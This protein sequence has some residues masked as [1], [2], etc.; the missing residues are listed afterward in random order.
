MT[1]SRR[2]LI[3]MTAAAAAAAALLPAGA[4]QASSPN[5]PKVKAI[6]FDGF[7]IFDPRPIAAMT[8]Q[9]FPGHGAALTGLWRTKI[10]EYTWL[11][12]SMQRYR[13][14]I[15]VIEDAL[16][17]AARSMSLELTPQK[18]EMLVE[19]YH[20]MKAWPDVAPALQKL[21]AANLRLAYLN[22]FTPKMLT[23]NTTNA[24]LDGF[25]EHKLSTDAVQV[26]KP[27]PRAY[28]MGLD[29]FGL[30]REEILFVAFGGW[31]AVGAKT[32]GYPTFW[33]NRLRVSGEELGAV[34]DGEG[35][36]MDDL[37]KFLAI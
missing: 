29:A 36:G 11:R 5:L 37:L 14:F 2:T 12:T 26:Y 21:K 19:G 7:P 30:Q 6:A 31:D 32:F 20:Q 17:A 25:F 33:M 27:H 13:D 8:E 22:N 16:V 23:V 9:L 3:E 4:A 35:N 1:I 15:G 28:Q 18:R 24:G 34:P 10:F